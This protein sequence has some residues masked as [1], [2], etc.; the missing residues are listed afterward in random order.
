MKLV[1]LLLAAAAVALSQVS[2]GV[3]LGDVRDESSALVAGARITA[4]HQ[5]TGFTRTTVSG[6][7][8]EY[9]L[10]ELPPGAYQVAVEKEGFRKLTFDRVAV[11]V[12]Q[13]YRLDLR[14]Q[15]GGE[16]EEIIVTA[17]PALL[18]TSEASEGYLLRHEDVLSGVET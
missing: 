4:V 14:L 5:G 10:D 18:Q 8:G 3:L 17:P 15:V 2:S 13:K 11:E 7:L 6:S 16:R 12:N 9:R 1:V